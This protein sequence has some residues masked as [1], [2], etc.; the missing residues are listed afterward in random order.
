LANIPNQVRRIVEKYIQSLK[1]NNIPIEQAILFGSYS[2]TSDIDIAIVSDIF[3][4]DRFIDRGKIRKINLSVSKDL[5]ILPYNPQDFT[6]DNPFVKE[7]METGI[8]IV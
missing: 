6:I 1:E 2:E 8:K 7:I 4:G 5:E 3:E